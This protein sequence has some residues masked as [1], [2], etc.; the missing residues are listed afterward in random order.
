MFYSVNINEKNCR[1]KVQIV[2]MQPTGK[3]IEHISQSE[4]VLRFIPQA[5]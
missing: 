4:C 5:G 2:Q 3:W 1:E